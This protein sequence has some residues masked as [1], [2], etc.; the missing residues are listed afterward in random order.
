[1]CCKEY[2]SNLFAKVEQTVVFYFRKNCSNFLQKYSV[3]FW[4]KGCTQKFFWRGTNTL[5]SYYSHNHITKQLSW[6]ENG[7]YYYNY[8]LCFKPSLLSIWNA[9]LYLEYAYARFHFR[10]GHTPLAF[11]QPSL[12][13]QHGIKLQ[14]W[15]NHQRPFYVASP[16]HSTA[17]SKHLRQAKQCNGV[18]SHSSHLECQKLQQADKKCSCEIITGMPGTCQ[19][20][21][22]WW[23]WYSSQHSEA[24][25]MVVKLTCVLMRHTTTMF[26]Q[27]VSSASCHSKGTTK[28]IN[29]H[30]KLLYSATTWDSSQVAPATFHKC[31][32]LP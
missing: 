24:H 15:R 32:L 26:P 22:R 5:E 25:I 20:R 4:H 27:Q 18:P 3:H 19:A 13:G 8:S 28:K 12:E 21:C 7:G 2:W 9:I 6:L 11:T 16:T 29:E 17:W 30:T 1:M 14:Y 10:E 31:K 23:I